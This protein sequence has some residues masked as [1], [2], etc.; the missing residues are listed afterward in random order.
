MQFKEALA[1]ALLLFGA[2]ACGSGGD[3]SAGAPPNG[4]V[5]PTGGPVGTPLFVFSPKPPG[6]AT[7]I[8]AIADLPGGQKQTSE[9]EIELLDSNGS[10]APMTATQSLRA[11]AGSQER[12]RLA[13]DRSSKLYRADALRLHSLP[14][15]SDR[16][17]EQRRAPHRAAFVLSEKHA[18][19]ASGSSAPTPVSSQR[20]TTAA[21]SDIGVSQ[22]ALCGANVG[23]KP[24]KI[25]TDGTVCFMAYQVAVGVVATKVAKNRILFA[26][27]EGRYVQIYT[28]QDAYFPP[29]IANVGTTISFGCV[30]TDPQIPSNLFVEELSTRSISVGLGTFDLISTGVLAGNLPTGLTVFQKKDRS[31]ARGLQ[32]DS[33]FGLGV[34]LFG[35]EFPVSVSIQLNSANDIGPVLTAPKPCGMMGLGP[36]G[37]GDDETEQAV[38][39]AIDPLLQEIGQGKGQPAGKYV[40]AGT[41]GDAFQAIGSGSQGPRCE[42]CPASTIDDLS[43]QVVDAFKSS[44]DGQGVVGKAAPL[45]RQLPDA[46]PSP[47][48]LDVLLQRAVPGVELASDIYEQRAS[49]GKNIFVGSGLIVIDATVGVPVSIDIDPA[50]LATLMKRPVSDVVGATLTVDG[51]PQVDSSTFTLSDKVLTLTFTPQSSVSVA[52]HT[53]VDLTTAKGPFPPEAK[54]W[55]VAL[56][57]R[58][59]RPKPGPA[60]QAEISGPRQIVSGGS[61]ALNVIVLD[62]DGN[63]VDA[64]THVHF[65]DGDGMPIGDVQTRYSVA[66]VQYVPSAS[67]PVLKSATLST[68]THSDGTTVPGFILEG[69]GISVNAEIYADDNLLDPK[70]VPRDIHSSS[71]VL[72]ATTLAV[73]T[74]VHVVNPGGQRSNDVQVAPSP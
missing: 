44:S 61:V 26:T 7:G 30:R 37:S 29:D 23:D 66:T 16:L 39:D 5:G 3:S 4:S 24:D 63:P 71:E 59:V 15:S 31:Y 41:N 14:G 34:S 38:S 62:K 65:Q 57:P 72:V 12:E 9:F 21:G 11:A 20:R 42:G 55:Y 27:K 25:D 52:V 69:S 56:S 67:T 28:S 40:I 70:S 33:S 43:S 45:L 68:L 74:H 50:E 32:Y 1:S 73:G 2:T 19:S 35:I 51:S 36:S 17:S 10:A 18:S 6:R 54:D 47:R 64:P 49:N 46:L 13:I 8:R 22:Q 53:L 48:T 58:L 60:A